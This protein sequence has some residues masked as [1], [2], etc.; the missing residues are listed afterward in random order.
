MANP[1]PKPVFFVIPRPYGRGLL[2]DHIRRH[3]I[4]APGQPAPRPVTPGDTHAATPRYDPP[5]ANTQ[6]RQ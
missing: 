4:A 2:L 6:D 5:P 3:G 1:N